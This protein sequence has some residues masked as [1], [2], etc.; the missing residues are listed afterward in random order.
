M[1]HILV[2]A[3]SVGFREKIKIFLGLCL[4]FW[5]MIS[6][7]VATMAWLL[8]P[9]TENHV[10]TKDGLVVNTRSSMLLF[11][12]GWSGIWVRRCSMDRS[13]RACWTSLSGAP[14]LT[15]RLGQS[16]SGQ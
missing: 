8:M 15:V 9:G 13:T 2:D 4:V 12:E 7:S 11:L 3:I 14:F 5:V 1:L 16:I 10:F 6:I